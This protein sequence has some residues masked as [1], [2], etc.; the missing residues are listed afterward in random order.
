M[1]KILIVDDEKHI[2]EEFKGVLEEEHHSV[3]TAIN[4][5]EAIRKA[6]EKEYD[7]IFLDVLMPQMEGREVFEEIKK[8]SR[9]P[10]AIMSGYMPPNKEMDVMALGAIACLSKPLDLKR[11]RE[12]VKH[13]ESKK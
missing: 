11:V 5:K 13:V 9:V 2:C 7:L 4:G 1:A 10:V 12:L 8:I 3:D 6:G